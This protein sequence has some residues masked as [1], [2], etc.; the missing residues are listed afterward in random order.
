MSSRFRKIAM[1]FFIVVVVLPALVLLAAQLGAFKGTA[2][3]T[4]GIRDGRLK[5]P[6]KTPN[7][8]T[9]QSGLYPD[10]PQA[11]RAAIAPL[12]FKGDGKAAMQKIARILRG[13][14]RTEI[15][16]EQPGYLYAQC[17]TRLMR[18]TDD[19]EFMLDESAGVI[20]VRSASRI[21]HGDRGVN[22][23]RVE[24]V[25]HQLIAP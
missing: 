15:I 24:A 19:V 11:Q 16:T 20:H 13:M 18:F 7:S 17:T 5:P 22:R 4:L 2:P 25:R 3:T 21:G 14:D 10:H 9:S 1:T 6:A 8:V 23:A 12:A